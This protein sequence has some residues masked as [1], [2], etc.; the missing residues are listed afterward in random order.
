M[1]KDKEFKKE[2]MELEKK[3]EREF[4]TPFGFMR[5][6]SEDMEKLFEEFPGFHFPKLFSRDFLP[7]EKE[8]EKVDWVPQVEILRH[9]G[10][11]TVRAELPG[12][13][14]DDVKVEVNNDGLTLSGERKEE[15]EEKAEGYYRT[16]RSYGSFYRLIPLPKGVNVDKTTATFHNGLL[17]IKMQV[18][19][20]EERTRK[21]EIKE[22]KE[23][24]K[25]KAMTA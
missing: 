24:N 18:P 17:E 1:N 20:M 8:F 11:F 10:D 5:R 21:I 15:K 22:T 9:N 4:V 14:K 19:K 3:S 12:L 16:E 13:T 2:S 25:A 6:F 7:L 23:F